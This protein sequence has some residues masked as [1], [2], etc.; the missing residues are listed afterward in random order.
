MTKKSYQILTLKYKYI[1]ILYPFI[2]AGSVSFHFKVFPKRIKMGYQTY[3]K[4]F[5]M[6]CELMTPTTGIAYN[7]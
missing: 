2:F 5:E 1:Q 6:L 3:K 7:N 4:A